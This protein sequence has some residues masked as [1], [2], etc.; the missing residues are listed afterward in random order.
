MGLSSPRPMCIRYAGCTA[1]Q[2]GEH[3]NHMDGSEEQSSSEGRCGSAGVPHVDGPRA[4][5]HVHGR[6]APSGLRQCS[7]QDHAQLP[8]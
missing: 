2:R 5:G 4:V 8:H 1:L 6:A 3:S 7:C